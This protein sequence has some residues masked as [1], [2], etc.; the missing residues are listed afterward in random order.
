MSPRFW[1][2]FALL[3]P[4]HA[5]AVNVFACEPEWSALVDEI[6]GDDAD[7]RAGGRRELQQ[8]VRHPARPAGSD[9]TLAG[10]CGTSGRTIG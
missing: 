8:D 3:L 6:A 7:Q 2:L 9:A 5:E 1:F 4:M 10:N